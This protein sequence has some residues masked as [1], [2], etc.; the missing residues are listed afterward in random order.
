M[1]RDLD[2]YTRKKRMKTSK[3]TAEIKEIE[4][5]HMREV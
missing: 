1:P 5:K 2:A 4:N 3:L